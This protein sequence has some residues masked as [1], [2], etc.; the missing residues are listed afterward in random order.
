MRDIA[1]HE[2][3]TS[4]T[5]KAISNKT[6]DKR[7]YDVVDVV[8]LRCIA[9][10]HGDRACTEVDMYHQAMLSGCDDVDKYCRR[11][12]KRALRRA[13]GR[14]LVDND[15]MI[16]RDRDCHSPSQYKVRLTTEAS[17]A[18]Q[19]AFISQGDGYPHTAEEYNLGFAIW[20]FFSLEEM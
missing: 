8:D 19:E 5:A 7:K 9:I 17:K 11:M 2:K 6:M 15:C 3:K 4:I 14:E 13:I 18:L 1:T 10:P 20:H 16:V 12:V